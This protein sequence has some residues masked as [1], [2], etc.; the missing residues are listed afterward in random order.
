MKNLA[1]FLVFLISADVAIGQSS[2]T[3]CYLSGS[4]TKCILPVNTASMAGPAT[5]TTSG[6]L[7]S[8]DWTTFNG[9]QATIT[10]GSLTDATS[11]SVITVGSGTGAV[12][13]SGTTLTVS[14]AAANGNGYLSSADWQTF[15]GK[16][17]GSVTSVT[18]SSPLTG[19]TITTS[20]LPDWD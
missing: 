11:P 6:Y 18:A 14:K 17:S 1:F 7:A 16:G 2:M 5:A 20:G 10:E 13:G 3:A 4:F 8:G 12:I 9:T 19:G 15:N